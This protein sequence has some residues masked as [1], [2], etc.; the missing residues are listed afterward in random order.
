MWT[1][2]E[3]SKLSPGELRGPSGAAPAKLR[4]PRGRWNRCQLSSSSS[5]AGLCGR[6]P[7]TKEA[8]PDAGSWDS[9]EI[10]ISS[11]A[12]SLAAPSARTRAVISKH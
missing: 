12:Y 1:H 6:P 9:S 8:P 5:H 3:H 7:G 4:A 10:R 11:E 2:S